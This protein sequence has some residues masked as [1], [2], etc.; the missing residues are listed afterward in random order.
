MIQLVMKLYIVGCMSLIPL[1]QDM[2]VDDAHIKTINN[3]A[4]RLERQN[5]DEMA[6]VKKRR[7]QLNE[8]SVSMHL[9]NIN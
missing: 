3:L 8:R 5:C 7:Q 2:T 4:A 9:Y 6:T 1:C